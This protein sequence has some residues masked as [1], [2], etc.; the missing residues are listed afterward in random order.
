MKKNR[1][2]EQDGER[3]YTREGNYRHRAQ[4]MQT[5]WGSST[6][7]TCWRNSE[8]ACVAGAEGTRREREE[9][10]A[11][12][13]EGGSWRALRASGRTRA[14]PPGEVR[15]QEG[16]GPWGARPESAAHGRPLVAA[17]GRTGLGGRRPE[18]GIH[19]GG[20]CSGVPAGGRGGGCPRWG[21]N[22]AQD[23]GGGRRGGEG[24]ATPPAPLGVMPAAS[25]R[26][27]SQARWPSRT[28]AGSN[29]HFP[30]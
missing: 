14:F 13:G 3:P 8:K 25:S 20:H 17:A 7:L 10:R 19:G 28:P 6:G 26:G 9:G 1:A 11:G 4:P 2:G 16:C 12:R 30:L 18:P 21:Q 22:R 15:V 29:A 27:R 5:S 23:P 24:P